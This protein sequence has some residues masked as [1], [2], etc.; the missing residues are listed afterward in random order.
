MNEPHYFTNQKV[1]AS[2]INETLNNL[3]QSLTYK[4]SLTSTSSHLSPIID[5][6]SATVKTVTNRVENATGQ[7]DR[8]GRR[9]QI[10]E[11]YPVYQFNLAGNG[12]TPVSYTHLTLPTTMWV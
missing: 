1:V 6:S 9:D 11:F 5:L 3:S 12:G 7:E 8:F 4:M 10:V 2:E